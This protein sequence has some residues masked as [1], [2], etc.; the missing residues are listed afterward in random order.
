MYAV[1]N[2][3]GKQYRASAD[4]ELVVDRLPGEVGETVELPVSFKADGD[5]FDFAGSQAKVEILE[6]LRGEKIHIY[7]YRPKKTY[8]KKTGHRQE[9]TRVKVTEV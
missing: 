2:A 4:Q 7:K 6:H 9:L 1:L 5:D 3:G 8:K